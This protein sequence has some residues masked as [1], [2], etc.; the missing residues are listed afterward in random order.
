MKHLTKRVILII[1]IVLGV[2]IAGVLAYR[3]YST[4]WSIIAVNLDRLAGIKK[5]VPRPVAWVER[6]ATYEGED[7]WVGA[8][9]PLTG[10]NLDSLAKY[11]SN[12]KVPIAMR[13]FKGRVEITDS[14]FQPPFSDNGPPP[15]L[16]SGSVKVGDSTR[17]RITQFTS[18]QA[19]TY[20]GMA[21]AGKFSK[22]FKIR[23]DPVPASLTRIKELQQRLSDT[24]RTK[25][26]GT[27]YIRPTEQFWSDLR[28]Y[29]ALL[30]SYPQN[31]PLRMEGLRLCSQQIP[32]RT[33]PQYQEPD[34][35]LLLNVVEQLVSE[36]RADPA[37]AIWALVRICGDPR[38]EDCLFQ[39][40]KASGSQ[41]MVAAVTSWSQDQKIIHSGYSRK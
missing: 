29:A 18:L 4:P 12:S 36:P 3:Y 11:V 2:A 31:T 23:V 33:S 34:S 38:G 41:E 28:T 40:A 27:F 19:G 16:F 30:L 9:I 21:D 13:I 39:L 26:H 17:W 25:P 6:M 20:W 7:I 10:G 15:I 37:V 24:L 14:L 8:T 35:T 32:D 22:K 5:F 1:P